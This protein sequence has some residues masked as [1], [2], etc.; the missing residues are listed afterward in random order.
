MQ[1]PQGGRPLGLANPRTRAINKSSTRDALSETQVTARV[2]R[3]FHW[4]TKLTHVNRVAGRKPTLVYGDKG[5]DS[6]RG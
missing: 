5:L 1:L 4:C 6:N 2:I 3:G